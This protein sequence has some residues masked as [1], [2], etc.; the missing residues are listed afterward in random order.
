MVERKI[1][2]MCKN[3]HR[4]S[5]LVN[6][7]RRRCLVCSSDDLTEVTEDGNLLV[8]K[9]VVKKPV[10]IVKTVAASSVSY[11]SRQVEDFHTLADP[12]LL[13]V[14]CSIADGL[15]MTI[16]AYEALRLYMDEADRQSA[17]CL[18]IT[19]DSA[20]RVGY[21]AIWTP[22]QVHRRYGPKVP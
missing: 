3:C 16:E 22:E 19:P 14:N 1:T 20:F 21:T 10:R 11:I 13:I 8:M 4:L 5:Q 2:I 7:A 17:Q 6:F 9:P 18:E 12:Y 15:L